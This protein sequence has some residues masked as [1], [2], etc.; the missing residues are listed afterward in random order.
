MEEKN[1]PEHIKASPILTD[2]HLQL[3]SKIEEI[4]S[5]E[6]VKDFANE[7][8]VRAILDSFDDEENIQIELHRLASDLINEG[9]I[10]TAWSV[11]MLG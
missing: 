1:I 2:N 6:Q 10:D 3:L 11:L 9:E 4:P 5:A 7:P 8:E